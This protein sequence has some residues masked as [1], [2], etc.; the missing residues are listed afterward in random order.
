[1]VK[2]DAATEMA[3]YEAVLSSSYFAG[4][5]NSSR[6]L[7]YVCDKYF[8]GID[9]VTEY[10]IAVEA[11]DRRADFDPQ[12][13]SIV[14][15]EAHRIR[16]RLH[17]YYKES[18]A[19]NSLRLVLP[20]GSYMPQFVPESKGG[21]A[22]EG[23]DEETIPQTEISALSSS[24]QR[25]LRPGYRVALSSLL[26]TGITVVGLAVY[27][28]KHRKEQ[29]PVAS[30]ATAAIPEAEIASSEVLI[31]AGSSAKGYTDQLG[32]AWSADR[33]FDGGE[34]WSVP[35]RRILRTN[36]PQLFLFARQ[37][38]NFGYDIPL[39]RGYYELR[40]YFAETFYGD[41]NSEGGGESS[42]MFDVSANG[43]L[44]LTNFDPL[45]DA[46]ADNTADVRVFSGI[47][48]AADGFLHLRFK[49]HWTLKGVAFVNA[50]Q[51]IRTE[52]KTM[53]PVR[54][55]TGNSTIVDHSGRSWIP[56]EFVQGGRRRD[57]RQEIA[58][59]DDPELYQSERYGN[60][61]YAIPVA[62]D[63]TYTLTLHF[64]EHWFG[65][66]NGVLNPGSSDGAMGKRV[67][68]V[69]CN[70]VNLIDDLDIYKE[71]GGSL[72]ALTKTFHRLTP[73]HQGKLFLSFVPNQDYAT[74]D[75]LEVVPEQR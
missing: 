58:N 70:G 72:K 5:T 18:G 41:D 73:N 13:D 54:W 15:V 69:Y 75:A 6:F 17:E 22:A 66:P 45:S 43:A 57:L 44:L 60:F 46:G 34:S 52:G 68:D 36:D 12:Q 40:L 31:M 4:Q 65:A 20:Q 8:A 33:F 10:E 30:L 35:Y 49:N 2:A 28:H 71:S 38:Q 27:A 1:V 56:D 29:A 7:R 63:A 14:R 67:F 24:P 16:K 37:G 23:N 42:R 48:P 32:H 50:I 74:V 19:N 53:L 64:S 59:T 11:L 62:T 39:K 51:L 25:R 3:E 47:S 21:A 61:S 55:T 9:H 26:L